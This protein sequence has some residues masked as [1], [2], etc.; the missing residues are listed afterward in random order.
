MY[1]WGTGYLIGYALA[2]IFWLLFINPI[3]RNYFKRKQQILDRRKKRLIRKLSNPNNSPTQ[4]HSS[5]ENT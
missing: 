1:T 5:N 3:D 2:A 4:H